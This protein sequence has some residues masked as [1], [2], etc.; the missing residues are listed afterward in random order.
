MRGLPLAGRQRFPRRHWSMLMSAHPIGWPVSG[1][2]KQHLHGAGQLFVVN[3]GR[4]RAVRARSRSRSRS[5]GGRRRAPPRPPPAGTCLPQGGPR[6]ATPTRGPLNRHS[7]SGA[8]A[9]PRRSPPPP[10][11]Q[12][13]RRAPAA[14]VCAAPALVWGTRCSA[15]FPA[16]GPSCLAWAFPPAAPPHQRG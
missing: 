2:S 7:H 3:R 8:R 10:R 14:F 1:G 16:P 11:R 12:P 6:E 5:V 15:P 9:G 4:R 13:C